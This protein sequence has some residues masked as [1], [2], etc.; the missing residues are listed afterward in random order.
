MK[1]FST[2]MLLTLLVLL[3]TGIP[4][5]FLAEENFR[6]S[7]TKLMHHNVRTVAGFLK[8]IVENLKKGKW[9][10]H[11]ILAIAVLMLQKF[12]I[13]KVGNRLL[14]KTKRFIWR[15]MF[16]KTLV[17]ETIQT[18]LDEFSIFDDP[19]ATIQK[20]AEWDFDINEKDPEDD[21]K[22]ILYKFW[23]ATNFLIKKLSLH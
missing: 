16:G 15:K 3:S 17:G 10:Y 13:K 6:V 9:K 12:G 20:F 23:K 8:P 7:I 19:G 18:M 1:N 11:I 22:T 2:K 21:D 4:S 14:F 5:D